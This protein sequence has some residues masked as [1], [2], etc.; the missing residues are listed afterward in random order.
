MALLRNNIYAWVG[1][2]SV[3]GLDALLVPLFSALYTKRPQLGV[4]SFR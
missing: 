4:Q 3:L 1:E 2:S